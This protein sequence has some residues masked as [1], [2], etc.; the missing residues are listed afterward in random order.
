MSLTESKE[1]LEKK[2]F[3]YN[4]QLSQINAVLETDENNEQYIQIQKDLLHLISLTSNL[5]EAVVHST[6]SEEEHESVMKNPIQKKNTSVQLHDRIEVKS[7]D[8]IYAGVV[9]EIFDDGECNVKYFE[10]DTIVKLPLTS[11]MHIT[12]VEEGK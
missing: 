8:R 11:L 2:I 4:Q 7:N 12:P 5:M 9:L 3:A 6:A 1:D 10:Y